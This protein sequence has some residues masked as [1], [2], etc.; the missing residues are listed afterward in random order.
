LFRALQ[1]ALAQAH[2][3]EDA[4]LEALQAAQAIQPDITSEQDLVEDSPADLAY[5]EA[6]DRVS[7]LEDYLDAC[8]DIEE[9]R[10][11]QLQELDGKLA[12][13][14]FGSTELQEITESMAAD[15]KAMG[16]QL[17]GMDKSPRNVEEAAAWLPEFL[18]AR[19]PP[20][21]FER[22]RQELDRFIQDGAQNDLAVQRAEELRELLAASG[23][24]YWEN[25]AF[26]Q[27]V[28]HALIDYVLGAI[29]ASGDEYEGVEY[30]GVEYNEG[31]EYNGDEHDSVEYNG[32]EYDGDE[33][34]DHA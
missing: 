5:W 21:R 14:L 23:V 6:V 22:F 17:T 7:G 1:T 16:I 9:E 15:L 30:N 27:F 8:M 29:L 31:V 28:F 13:Q 18:R 11:T 34:D 10:L 26:Q 25:V 20:E 33:Y 32:D 19:I 3:F 2:E 4:Q 24:S 12:D